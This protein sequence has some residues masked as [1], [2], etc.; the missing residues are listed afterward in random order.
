[1]ASHSPEA[2]I[3]LVDDEP[4]VTDAL[5][6]HFT[7]RQFLIRKATSA[8]EAYRILEHHRVDVV[9][10]DERMPGES[11]TEFLANVRSRYPNTIRIILSGQASLEAAVRAINEGEVYR[12]FLKPCN[13]TDLVFTISGPS[14]TSGWKS[15]AANYCRNF[16]GRVPCSIP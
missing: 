4:H 1:M 13:P 5:S 6:R 9:V 10:S 15:A 7:K 12:F 16:T 2:S 14:I 8:A 11:G 3:L